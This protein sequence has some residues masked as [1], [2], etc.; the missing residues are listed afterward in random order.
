MIIY[1]YTRW[2]GYMFTYT[3]CTMFQWVCLFISFDPRWS[4]NVEW[5]LFW[6]KEW[7]NG[8][9]EENDEKDEKKYCW[10]SCEQ[11]VTVVVIVVVA[12]IGTSINY[13]EIYAAWH[14]WWTFNN[15]NNHTT[16]TFCSYIRAHTH[17]NILFNVIIPLHWILII[18]YI[19]TSVHGEYPTCIIYNAKY[20]IQKYF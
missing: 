6:M 5:C 9:D 1:I 8:N 13:F 19:N 4:N 20:L 17:P 18:N 3:M 12:V 10:K 11:L 7:M 16:Y 2:I 14:D 15:N